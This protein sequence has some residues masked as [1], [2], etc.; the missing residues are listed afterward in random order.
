MDSLGYL[1]LQMQLEGIALTDQQLLW[2]LPIAEEDPPLVL[3]AYLASGKLM[4]YLSTGLSAGLQTMLSTSSRAFTFPQVDPLLQVLRSYGLQPQFGH[5]KTYRFPT[6]FASVADSSV[7]DY[8]THD[9]QIRAFG[10]DGLGEPVY[11]VALDGKIV[12]ACVS[13]R[14]NTHCGEAWVS[15]A[16]AYQQRGL[17]QRVV[18]VWAADLI[19]RGKIPFYSHKLDNRASARLAAHLGLEPVFEEISIRSVSA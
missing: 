7:K 19:N 1:H 10:F 15:T 6:R 16:P 13:V 2:R 3:I 17:A 12:S 8:S 11:A 5:Y 4:T 18:S 14:E 9:A